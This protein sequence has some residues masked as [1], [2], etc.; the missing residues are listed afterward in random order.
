ML[1]GNGD[2]GSLYMTM[3]PSGRM[4]CLGATLPE[5]AK[6][7]LE[8]D[9]NQSMTSSGGEDVKKRPTGPESFCGG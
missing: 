3:G 2:E 1:E 5:R 9:R 4:T 8:K 6:S 7:G